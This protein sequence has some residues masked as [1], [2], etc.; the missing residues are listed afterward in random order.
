MKSYEMQCVIPKMSTFYV[1]VNKLNI[2]EKTKHMFDN[3]LHGVS[4]RDVLGPAKGIYYSGG[5]V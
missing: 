2:V 5:R 4:F 3:E 1:S